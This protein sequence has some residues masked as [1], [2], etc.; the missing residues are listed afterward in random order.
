M[1]VINRSLAKSVKIYVINQVP[2]SGDRRGRK[3]TISDPLDPS[4]P[5]FRYPRSAS[6][7]TQWGLLMA[8]DHEVGGSIKTILVIVAQ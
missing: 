1:L 7:P 3:K 6:D 5:G 4:D 8:S 2:G